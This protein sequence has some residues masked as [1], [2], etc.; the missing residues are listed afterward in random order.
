M[1]EF[2]SLAKIALYDTPQRL[3]VLGIL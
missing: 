1:D 2:D 3:E